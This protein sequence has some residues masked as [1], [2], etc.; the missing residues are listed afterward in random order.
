MIDADVFI[1]RFMLYVA[2][3]QQLEKDYYKIPSWRTFKQLANIR[4]RERLTKDF[5]KQSKEW[6]IL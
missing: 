2:L 6:G 3:W 5:V 4:K 1:R